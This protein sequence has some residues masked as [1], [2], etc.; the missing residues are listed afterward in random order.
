VIFPDS[1]SSKIALEPVEGGYFSGCLGER[2]VGER[3][4][5][6]LDGE[7]RVADPASRSQP[8]GVHGPSALFDPALFEWSDGAFS[9]PAL[10][11]MVIYELHLGTFRAPLDQT[12]P[13][14]RRSGTFT[15]AAGALDDLA[16]L[17]V[18]AVEPLPIAAFPGERN[19]GYDGVFP[20]AVQASY[21]GPE[22]F[23]RFVDAAHNVG[24]A[25][26]L[27]VVYN[28]LGPEG[29]VQSNFGP[30]AASAYKTPWGDAMN[31]DRSGSDEVRRYFLENALQWFVDFHVDGLRLDAIHGIIDTSARPFL[32]ELSDLVGS[33]ADS[34][35]RPLFLIAESEDN[36]PRVIQPTVSGGLGMDAQWAD[37]FHHGLH[38][39]LTGERNGY[40]EDYVGIPDLAKAIGSGFSYTGQYSAHRGRRHGLAPIHAVPAQFTVATQNHD[41][42]GN[43]PDSARLSSLVS[44]AKLKIAAGVLLCSPQLPLLFMGEEDADPHP[45]AYFVDHTDAELLASVRAGRAVEMGSDG[46]FDPGAPETFARSCLDPATDE[47][48]RLA[49]RRFYGDLLAFRRA[50]PIVT[51]PVAQ[52]NSQAVT[53]EALSVARRSNLGGVWFACNTGARRTAIEVPRGAW[54]LRFD[55]GDPA[56]G[57][58]GTTASRR[59]DLPSILT[60]EAETFVCYEEVP[61]A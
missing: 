10:R 29:A 23:Q 22:G 12:V 61:D 7:L 41:Q 54:R 57:G 18:T 33:L 25:V 13:G 55:S 40:Y 5:F 46:S 24:L 30:Y 8:D 19:W 35:D 20:F 49:I 32:A 36:N 48:D 4:W 11:E 37:D 51:D 21:G 38:V 15:T 53:R 58:S 1:P 59:V 34:Y 26:V 16:S 14:G 56:Y 52:T 50:T 3:Y 2:R 43:R 31:F 44:F 28:H 6:E 17:G 42:V 60:L 39:A 27:D 45:F 47:S 9:P